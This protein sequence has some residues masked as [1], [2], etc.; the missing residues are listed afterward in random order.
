M[1]KTIE[2]VCKYCGNV[3]RVIPSRVAHGRGKCCSPACQY[4]SIKSRQGKKILHICIGCGK[5]FYRYARKHTKGSG[6]YCTRICRDQNR[7]GKNHP[8]YLNGVAQE[9]RGPNWAS[10]KRKA[11]KR[12]KHTCQ[13]CGDRGTDVHHI[14]PF[15]HFG[16]SNYKDANQLDNLKTLCHKCHRLEDIQIQKTERLGV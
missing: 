3:F 2:R 13:R 14:I 7:T 16:L 8:Q 10:Q 11:I 1:E 6:K 15:R 4:A 12:D 9:K 5:E